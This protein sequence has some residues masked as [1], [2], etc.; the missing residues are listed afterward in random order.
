ML[1]NKNIIV[2]LILSS[3]VF[4]AWSCRTNSGT[5]VTRQN[6]ASQYYSDQ[7][8][9]R[10]EYVLHNVTD[11]MSRMYFSVNSSELLYQKNN[12]DEGY[13]A[14]IILTYIVHPV[15]FPKIL[16]DSGR[17]VLSDVGQPGVSKL[18]A[19]HV[20]MDI[21]DT[22]EYYIEVIFRDLNKMTSSFELLYL[23]HSG[24]NARNNFLLTSENS[25]TPLYKTHIAKE[26]KF[27]I[28]YYS[29]NFSVLYVSW[30][31]NKT[32]PAPPPYS[33]NERHNSAKPDS[34]WKINVTLHDAIELPNEGFY[35]FS[36]DSTS[37]T[38]ITLTRFHEEY[39]KILI[40]RQ[41]VYP[42]RYLT[43]RDEYIAMD[44][45]RNV[46]KAVDD[47]WLN[48]TGSQ[49]RARE[50][51][52]NFYN[53]VE[54]TNTLFGTEIEG[55]K[56]DR[57]MIYLIFGPPENVYRSINSET[58]IYGNGGNTNGLSFVFDHKKDAFTDEEFI[59]VRNVDYRI[60]WITAV[61][62]WRQGHVYTLR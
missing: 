37:K 5:S 23:D 4:I 52:R 51:I 25:D 30:Y 55:W 28:R 19:S 40:A 41:L 60:N 59:L 2:L 14:R 13:T 12:Y 34:T 6:F 50:V 49:E 9:M 10:P 47:F 31:K 54:A 58:W 18:L 8:V 45:A 62:S 1:K 24:K 21:Y 11:S 39:P 38:G 53:R 36:I 42:L 32:G 3:A 15:A 26:E 35:T 56:T 29:E 7:K 17:V 27:S 43:M 22:D 33:T 44:T 57:G 48:S 61:D 16:T 46:K 20:D